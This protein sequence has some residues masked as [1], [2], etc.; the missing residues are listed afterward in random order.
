MLDQETITKNI[1]PMR[2]LYKIPTGVGTFD[3]II[4]GGFP[5][6]SL[7][8]LIGEAGAGN[9][10]FAYTSA[11][12]LSILK[13]NPELYDSTK[14]QRDAFMVNNESLKLVL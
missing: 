14:K 4:R 1:P 13:L 3:P 10:E 9:I 11:S 8:L 6:G 2:K 5:S 12:M 7:I